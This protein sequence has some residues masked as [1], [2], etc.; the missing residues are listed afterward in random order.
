M[1]T[2]GSKTPNDWSPDRKLLLYRDTN[3]RT[4]FD[5]M[6]V[7]VERDSATGGPRPSSASG[8]RRTSGY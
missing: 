4:G 2:P 7:S 1:E 6:V 8:G 5:L 3:V